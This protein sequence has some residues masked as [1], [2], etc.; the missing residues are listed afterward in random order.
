MLGVIVKIKT[1]NFQVET[2]SFNGIVD[3]TEDVQKILDNS[4]MKEGNALVFAIGST[5]GITTIE[6]EPGLLK[7]YPDFMERIVP[8]K[9]KYHHDET[10]HDGNGFAHVRSSLQGTSFTVPFVDTKLMLGTWQQ[11]I[12]VNFDNRARKRN[13][14]V[15]LI[16]E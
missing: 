7:D 11:I 5:V 13:I 6:Y 4:G 15:Q 16:G 12:L 2:K 9:S 10:W 14:I 8:A 3:I 1:E